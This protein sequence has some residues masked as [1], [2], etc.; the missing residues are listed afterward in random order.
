MLVLLNLLH[1]NASF[2]QQLLY[3]D[4]N[5]TGHWKRYIWLQKIIILLEILQDKNVLDRLTDMFSTLCLN[6]LLRNK[7]CVKFF[8]WI[9]YPWKYFTDTN[10]SD[11]SMFIYVENEILAIKWQIAMLQYENFISQYYIIIEFIS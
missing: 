1:Q 7:N 2:P 6:Y 4:H 11:Y 3:S 5:Y 10:F 9:H 8:W